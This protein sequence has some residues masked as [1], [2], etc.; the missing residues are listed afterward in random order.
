MDEKIRLQ[1]QIHAL[2][3]ENGI[4]LRERQTTV[5]FAKEANSIL[6]NLKVSYRVKLILSEMLEELMIINNKIQSASVVIENHIEELKNEESETGKNV[7][8]MLSVYGVGPITVATLVGSIGDM[9]QFKTG[10]QLSA[11]LGLTPRQF[12]SGGKS[13]LGSI[14]KQGNAH[15][16]SLLILCSH[17]FLIRIEKLDPNSH[18]VIWLK[19]KMKMMGKKKLVV[20]LANKLAR[21]LWAVSVKNEPF[22]FA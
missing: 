1:N 16:R 9:K 3:R 21:I 10:R 19:L 14:T 5:G 17:S 12:S 6:E 18:L 2:F 7:K 20:A 4:P 8:N 13:K 11:F 22:S 15:L